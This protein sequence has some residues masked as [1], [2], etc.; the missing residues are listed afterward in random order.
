MV[1]C[2]FVGF[3]SK[4]AIQDT[5]KS[6]KP[7]LPVACDEILESR[8][9]ETARILVTDFVP[10]KHFAFLDYENDDQWEQLCVPMFPNK[11]LKITHSYQ[12]VLICFKNVP[13][14]EAFKE[15]MASGEIDANY[16]PMRQNLDVAIHSQLAQQYK[17]LD[18]ANSP[19][20]HYGFEASNPVLGETSL[21]V[22][23]GIGAAAIF[24]A[25]VAVLAGLFLKPRSESLEDLITPEQNTNRAGLPTDPQSVG[26]SVLD[27]VSSMRDRQPV[28]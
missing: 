23:L 20:L 16:W 9:T 7:A 12:A 3:L 18:F 10:G 28:G 17:S 24:A 21:K 8:P 1:L 6:L 11:R 26:C 13:D 5:E 27:R 22:S 19:V 15:L 4:R 2:A 14:S 25:I